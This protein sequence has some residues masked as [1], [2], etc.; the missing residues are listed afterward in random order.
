MEERRGRGVRKPCVQCLHRSR[1]LVLQSLLPF[2][3]HNGDPLA[4]LKIN[5]LMGQIRMK[6]RRGNFFEGIVQKYLI[7][8]RHKVRL[9]M[10]PKS[11]LISDNVED[12]RRKLKEFNWA[13]RAKISG[14]TLSVLSWRSQ[15]R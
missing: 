4:I 3:N 9:I 10:T 8:N 6:M 11:S 2:L 13:Q 15:N 7:D 14:R 12:E 1:N 5:E